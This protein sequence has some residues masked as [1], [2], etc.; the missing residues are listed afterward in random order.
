MR[1]PSPESGADLAEAISRLSATAASPRTSAGLAQAELQIEEVRTDCARRVAA[2]EAARAEAV[3]EA[4]QLRRALRNAVDQ[5]QTAEAAREA[6]GA[7]QR[8]LE[9]LRAEV[10]RLS[11]EGERYVK[12]VPLAL[13]EAPPV[14]T[15]VAVLEHRV[16]AYDRIGI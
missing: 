2:A 13:D 12:W 9:E 14:L 16:D 8:Q 7:Q 15:S 4:E 11:A 10:A 5:L 1:S 6:D 3:T